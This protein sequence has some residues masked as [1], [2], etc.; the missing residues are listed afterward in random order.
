M[1]RVKTLRVLKATRR[2]VFRVRWRACTP[3]DLWTCDADGDPREPLTW[4]R[5]EEEY[6]IQLPPALERVRRDW[7]TRDRIRPPGV[8]DQVPAKLL[9]ERWE[10]E[11]AQSVAGAELL[12]NYEGGR[13]R[14]VGHLMGAPGLL[15]CDTPP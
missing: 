9:W 13:H 3:G 15:P 12:T 8:I 5:W 6:F 11:A 1:I 10:L 2:N 14:M 4:S 7:L